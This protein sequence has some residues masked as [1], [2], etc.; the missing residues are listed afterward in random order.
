MPS[1]DKTRPDGKGRPG[2]GLGPCSSKK[3]N[4]E[5]PSDD[6]DSPGGFDRKRRGNTTRQ[7]A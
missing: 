6:T 2:K 5:T 7:H 4:R 3:R 1:R